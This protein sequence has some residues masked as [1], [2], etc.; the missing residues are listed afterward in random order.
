MTFT[1]GALGVHVAQVNITHNA[2]G[3]PSTV[4]VQGNGVGTPPVLV[5]AGDTAATAIP[6]GT[7][8][9]GTTRTQNVTVTNQG[10]GPLLID[11]INVIQPI[12]GPSQFTATRGTCTA[13]V[14]VGRSCRLSVTYHAD[15]PREDGDSATLGGQQRGQRE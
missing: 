5:M 2:T 14:A 1:P 8:R 7:R 13:P 15:S 3:S 9:I 12:T 11:A 4:S 10:P 6:F